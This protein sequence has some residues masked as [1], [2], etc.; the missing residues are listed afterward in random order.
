MAQGDI[1]VFDLF[2]LDLCDGAHDFE[3]DSF[4]VGLISEGT[5]A[6]STADLDFDGSA[7]FTEVSGTNYTAGGIAVDL[8]TANSSGTITV[9]AAEANITWTQHASGQSNIK[10][11]ILY[12]DTHAN[13]HAVCAWDLTQDGGTTAIDLGDGDIV[14]TF[15]ASGIFTLA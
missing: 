14:L 12:N 9:D 13:D 11:A 1:T 6:A 5:P 10:T 3:N 2:K 15:N 7:S 8:S 4:K